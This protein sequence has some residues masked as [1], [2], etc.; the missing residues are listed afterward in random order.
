MCEGL[1]LRGE[2]RW[3]VDTCDGVGTDCDHDQAGDDHELTNLRWLSNECH[4]RKTV[5]ERQADT[6]LRWV[7]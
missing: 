5:L 1:S 4:K 6:T 3:H 2:D 7:L